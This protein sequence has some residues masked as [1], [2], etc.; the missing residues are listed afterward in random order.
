[1]LDDISSIKQEILKR[2]EKEILDLIFTIAEKIVNYRISSDEATVKAAIFNALNIS[3]EKSKI[4]LNVN[5]ETLRGQIADVAHGRFDLEARAE[6]F[7]YSSGFGRRFDNY[8]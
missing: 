5:V 8:Q 2:Y 4:V 6:I 3:V 1:M 7:V